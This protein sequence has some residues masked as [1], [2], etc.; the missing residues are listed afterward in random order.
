MILVNK[1]HQ[2]Y[3]KVVCAAE[4]YVVI[5]VAELLIIDINLPCDGTSDRCSVCEDIFNDLLFWIQKYPTHKI[6]IGGDFNT[7]FDDNCTVS[8]VVKKFTDENKLRRCDSSAS[9][10]RRPKEFTYFNEA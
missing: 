9:G 6:L 4:R 3:V 7:N 5:A 2:K 1:K 10:A 8:E